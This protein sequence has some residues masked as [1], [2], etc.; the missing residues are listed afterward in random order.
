MAKMSEE[1]Y[2]MK[3]AREKTWSCILSDGTNHELKPNGND[4]YV[5]Y[6]DRLEYIEL[7]KNARIHESDKQVK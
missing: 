3:F 6:E 5:N 4:E 2:N 1:D 7:V